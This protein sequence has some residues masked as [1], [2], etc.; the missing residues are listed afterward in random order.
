MRKPSLRILC[1][2]GHLGFAPT[3]D[4]SFWIGAKTRPDYYCFH[5]GSDDIGPGKPT[6]S[7]VDNIHRFSTSRS[8]WR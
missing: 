2:N 7:D 5:S 6:C 1:P 3:K 8:P 4:G